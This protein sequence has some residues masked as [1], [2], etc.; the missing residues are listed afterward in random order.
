V[1]TLSLV[2]LTD[3][4]RVVI[5][6]YDKDQVLLTKYEFK[7]SGGINSE[8]VLKLETSA[9][10]LLETLDTEHKHRLILMKIPRSN[11]QFDICI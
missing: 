10:W 11:V 7:I 9:S 2:K 1:W 6:L 4:V 5:L 8:F 3:E